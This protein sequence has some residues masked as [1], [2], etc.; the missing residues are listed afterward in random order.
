MSGTGN[1]LIVGEAAG[2]DEEIEGT[3]FVGKSGQ[4]LFSNLKRI[5]LEREQ[6]TLANVCA[7]RPPNNELAGASYEHEAIRACEPIRQ[8][9]IRRYKS[10]VQ[11]PVALALGRIAFRVSLSRLP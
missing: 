7:C 10:R 3:G 5:G 8:D 2:A 9:E 4:Y 1:V 11:H 6:F